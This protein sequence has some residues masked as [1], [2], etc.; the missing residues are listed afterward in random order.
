VSFGFFIRSRRP[1]RQ[2]PYS[3]RVPSPEVPSRLSF[4]LSFLLPLPSHLILVGHIVPSYLD[5]WLSRTSVLAL[6]LPDPPPC[7][8]SE[9]V[10]PTPSNLTPS[11]YRKQVVSAVSSSGTPLSTVTWTSSLSTS[12]LGR[13]F[14]FD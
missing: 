2:H 14:S 11:T 9:L 6:P 10:P 1:S 7:P 4:A 8:T 13:F 3:G 12:E 5:D